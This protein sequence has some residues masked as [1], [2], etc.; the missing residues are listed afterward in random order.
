MVAVAFMRWKSAEAYREVLQ[1]IKRETVGVIAVPRYMGDW[2]SAMR[3]AFREEFP[4]MRIHGCL[5]HFAQ[6]LWKRASSPAVGLASLIKRPSPE[7][8]KMLALIPLP[9]LP[10]EYI[11]PVFELC[12]VEAESL[13]DRPVRSAAGM[14]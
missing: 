13:L 4:T 10:A 3:R 14:I 11:T 1:T 8:R 12:A 9:L 6:A 2:D 7:L 5:L